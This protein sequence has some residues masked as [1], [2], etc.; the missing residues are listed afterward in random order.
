MYETSMDIQDL[1]KLYDPHKGISTDSRRIKQGEIY[2]AL[3]GEN[4]DGNRFA[5]V[6]LDS[7]ASIAIVDDPEVVKDKRY[8][9]V[10][11]S[12]QTLQELAGFHRQKMDIPVVGITGSNG[13]TTTK[14]LIHI[15][16]SSRYRVSSTRGNLNNHIG[17][18]L[19]L[20]EM[21]NQTEMAIIE[22][23]ANHKGEIARLCEIVR[24]DYGLV[25]NVG[26]AHLQGFGSLAGVKAAKGEIYSFIG[27]NGGLVFCNGANDELTGMLK[28]FKGGLKYY[29]TKGSLCHGRVL[30][31]DPYLKLRLSLQ[32]ENDIEFETELTGA[33]NLE[34]IFA[35]AAIGIHFGI[36]AGEIR[37]AIESYRAKSNRS[38]R[39]DTDENILI[40]DA[41]NANPTSMHSALD[42]F[43]KHSHKSKL[44]ILG[45]MH[46]LGSSSVEEH[47]DLID[48]LIREKYKEVYLVGEVFK[49]LRVPEEFIVF[50]T[51]KELDA[52]LTLHP[53]KNR[54]ILL[55]GSRAVGLEQLTG[56][57]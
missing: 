29:G 39:L 38:Q 46:E 48:L 3:K 44:L 9:L 34:N 15:V 53:V 43:G 6:A 32:D 36:S 26:K 11:D 16:L 56:N 25:T 27:N 30:K 14:E 8:I 52:W 7:G 33:Y 35:A 10:R 2:F 47:Q 23:G 18:P 42:A 45:E 24:P 12:L 41:Y 37:Y 49:N 4:F 1:Y 22:M 19:T 55:K 5:S 13:K 50:N 51:T 21:N 54:M 57:L 31:S 28:G 40:L 20:L 17:V